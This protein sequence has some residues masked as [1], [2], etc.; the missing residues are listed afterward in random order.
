MRHRPRRDIWPGLARWSVVL[1]LLGLGAALVARPVQ[2]GGVVAVCSEAA[3]RQALSGGGTVTFACGP[4]TIVV[5]SPLVITADTVLDGG[6]QITL[7]GG[8]L[9]GVLVTAANRTVTVRNLSIVNGRSAGQGAGLQVGANNTLT[10]EN[11]I[12]SGNVSTRDA[13]LCDGGGA[14]FIGGGSQ[15]VITGSTFTNNQAQNGGALNSLRSDLTITGSAFSGNSAVHSPAMDAR[16]DCGGGG[17]VYIDGADGFD[18]QPSV[19]VIQDS[20][21]TGNTTN[22]H[23]G[24]VFIGLYADETITLQRVVITGNSAVRNTQGQAGTGGGVWYGRGD[25]GQA[26]NALVIAEAAFVDNH[27]DTQGGGLWTDAPVTVRNA[28]FHGNDATNPAALAPDDWRRGNGGAIAENLFGGDPA[29]TLTNVT[30]AANAAGFNGGAIAGDAVRL[31]NTVFAANTGGNP[32]AIQQHCTSALTDEGGNFQHPPRNPS[33][34]Y[35]NETNCS[36]AVTLADPQLAALA[37]N[38]GPGATLALLPGSPA[39]DA[40]VAA[41]CPGTDQRGV[42]RALGGACDSGAYER[43]TRLAAVPGAVAVA[44]P[45]LTLEVHGDA[46]IPGQTITWNGSPLTTTWVSRFRL[47][48][49]LPPS[50]HAAP[51]TASVAVSGLSL[52]AATVFV[53]ADLH[54]VYLPAAR[55]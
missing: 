11:V 24:A 20:T 36:A 15:A 49:S 45:A 29:L 34:W 9:S 39:L 3:L 53:W 10:L 7:S 26:I 52:T 51:G 42:G 27:A 54:R 1:G 6:G 25:P 40:G 48:A 38:G 35:W 2:A 21:F 32:W 33:P 43:V 44:D 23:G 47:A 22:N 28:T 19:S 8:N 4:A 17:A 46:F 18:G 13:A 31:R 30:L 16:G 37:D 41:P 55:R 5:A 50:A 14:L 12:F